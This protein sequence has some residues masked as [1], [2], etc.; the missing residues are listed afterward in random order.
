MILSRTSLAAASA[1]PT[2]SPSQAAMIIMRDG[3]CRALCFQVFGD[4]VE[5]RR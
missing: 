1:R 5:Q 2:I 3:P 4:V